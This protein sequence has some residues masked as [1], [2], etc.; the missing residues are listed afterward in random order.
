MMH[1]HKLN[2]AQHINTST[3]ATFLLRQAV[4]DLGGE[5]AITANFPDRLELA[6]DSV[7]TMPN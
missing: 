4:K 5:L 7:K 6:I 2:V 1:H 3:P